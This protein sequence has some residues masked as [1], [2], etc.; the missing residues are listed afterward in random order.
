[1]AIILVMGDIA[2]DIPLYKE[3]IMIM[4]IDPDLPIFHIKTVMN[5]PMLRTTQAMHTQ[6]INKAEAMTISLMVK[7]IA[8][9]T[10]T[11][12]VVTINLTAETITNSALIDKF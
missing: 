4:A 9:M 2:A 3:I 5:N 8:A 6:A 10:I 11:A 12:T 7:I 1:M